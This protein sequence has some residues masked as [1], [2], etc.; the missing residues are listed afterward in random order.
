MP[1]TSYLP[2][3]MRQTPSG[4]VFEEILRLDP[5]FRAFYARSG[6]GGVGL[7]VR[8]EDLGAVLEV[9][10]ALPDDAGRDVVRAALAPYAVEE[11]AITD[12]GSA[13]RN[14]TPYEV[15]PDFDR[16]AAEA[17]LLALRCM[18]PFP[19]EGRGWGYAILPCMV[20]LPRRDVLEHL[21]SLPKPVTCVALGLGGILAVG[22]WPTEPPRE[23][24]PGV[25]EHTRVDRL[26]W[27]REN[28]GDREVRGLLVGQA[29]ELVMTAQEIKE[30]GE[31][32]DVVGLTSWWNT[33][34]SLAR[35]RG[36]DFVVRFERMQLQEPDPEL[37][38]E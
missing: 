30:W 10:R 20:P 13:W 9:L 37:S 22:A 6:S 34:D 24:T 15:G 5:E 18:L 8:A 4:Q 12:D 23:G 38:H 1:D 27:L 32:Y 19:E 29:E 35:E 28:Y 31:Q 11:P 7:G 25:F 36:V 21:M 17:T 14:R 33:E 26:T 2:P 16:R 3:E